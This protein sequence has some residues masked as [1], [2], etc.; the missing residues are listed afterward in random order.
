MVFNIQYILQSSNFI[1]IRV[2]G[3][4]CGRK[5]LMIISTP[6]QSHPRS[7]GTRSPSL[8]IFCLYTGSHLAHFARARS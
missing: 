7:M 3:F 5:N 1:Q 6:S 2:T 8:N 4:S